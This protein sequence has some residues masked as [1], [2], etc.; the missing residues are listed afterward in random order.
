MFDPNSKSHKPRQVG[1]ASTKIST[2]V[3][4]PEMHR[5]DRYEQLA[6]TFSEIDANGDKELS[7]EEIQSFLNRRIG[8]AFD[9][10]LLK[11]LFRNLDK[12]HNSVV[13]TEEFVNSYVEAERLVADHVATLE[14][15][16]DENRAQLTK[17]LAEKRSADLN[18]RTNQSGIMEDSILTVH[19]IEAQNL[20]P[21]DL[22][23]TSDPY[24]ELTCEGQKIETKVVK[25]SLNPFWDEKFTFAISQGN[26]DLKITVWD[27]DKLKKDFEGSLAIPLTLIR[28][29]MKH[30]EW[31]E[32]QPQK[33]GERWQGRI[34]LSLQWIWSRRVYY[35]EMAKQWQ[36]VID[37]DAEQLRSLKVNLDKLREPF[38]E[39]QLKGNITSVLR[40]GEIQQ[41]ETV[42][43]RRLDNVAL[44]AFGK[45]ID[46]SYAALVVTILM[47]ASSTLTCYARSDFLSVRPT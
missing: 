10:E 16:L 17:T 4:G 33:K 36:A 9:E 18:E 46:W 3:N 32:L 1:V 24:V 26:D 22:S 31:F 35:E 25:D 37:D 2:S 21:M 45:E 23:G 27:K 43:S 14:R 5:D 20:K 42:L 34:H 12:D 38:G 30:E 19:I 29:Q 6:K 40:S 44:A 13:T 15:Q 7:F 11:E 28:D 8:A 47:V 41:A 39:P